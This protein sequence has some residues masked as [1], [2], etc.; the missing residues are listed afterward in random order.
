MGLHLPETY[1]RLRLNIERS[2]EDLMAI[3]QE[4]KRSSRRIVGYCATSKST[5][6]INYCGFT[7]ELLEFISDTTS[8]KQGKFS[9]G[10]HIPV[11]PYEDFSRDYPEYALLFAWN[12]SEEIMAKEQRF[13]ESGGRWIVYVPKVEI[14]K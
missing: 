6:V 5:T 3:L 2:R 8:I 10:V 9:P 13:K 4:A 12:H 11:R 14:L 1:Y 7:P